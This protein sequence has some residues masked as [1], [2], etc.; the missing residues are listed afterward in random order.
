[1]E[2]KKLERKKKF[3]K[4]EYIDVDTGE[5]LQY[6]KIKHD[7][8]EVIKKESKIYKDNYNKQKYEQIRYYIRRIAEQRSIW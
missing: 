1:M 8:I 5:I 3:L 7:E 2:T 6:Q 4:N